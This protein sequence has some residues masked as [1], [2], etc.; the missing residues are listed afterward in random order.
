VLDSGLAFPGVA[1]RSTVDDHATP[2]HVT[3]APGMTPGTHVPL[4]LEVS[5]TDDGRAYVQPV[6]FE[7]VIGSSPVAVSDEPGPL[8]PSRLTASPNPASNLVRFST[9]PVAARGRLDIFAPD[10]S[11]LAS[12]DV[13]GD[14]T[15][16]CSRV[17]AGVYFC[18]IAAD[19][20]CVTTRV[21][22][23]H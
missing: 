3:A 15:W 22:V 18:R 9:A 19:R 20:N 4:R 21:T 11:R 7:V 16:N 14:C 13:R 10:G 8:Y 5:Y 2:F 23:T 17:P 12:A 6:D 1:R